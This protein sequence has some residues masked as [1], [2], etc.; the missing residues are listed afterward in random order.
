[1]YQAFQFNLK[2][3]Q[4][5]KLQEIMESEEVAVS[6]NRQRIGLI[7]RTVKVARRNGEDHQGEK[8]KNLIKNLT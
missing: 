3:N 6:I 5:K 7:R 8:I 2:I 4:Q 1:M